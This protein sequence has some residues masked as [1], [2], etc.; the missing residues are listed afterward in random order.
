MSEAR[1]I[2]AE[3]AQWLSRRADPDW[4]AG[5]QAELDRWLAQGHAHK[6]AFWR[7]QEGWD[8]AGRLSALGLP[9]QMK[10]RWTARRGSAW[11]SAALAASAAVGIWVGAIQ[12]GL[13]PGGRVSQEQGQ[14]IT[15]A[16]GQHRIVPLDDGSAIELNTA[17]IVRAAV[18]PSSREV[19]LDKGEAFFDVLHSNTVPFVVHAGPNTVTVLGTKFSV[20]RDGNDVT[21]AVL[22]GRVRLSD[23]RAPKDSTSTAVAAGSV[24]ITK[25]DATLVTEGAPQTVQAELAWR[26]GQL[27]FRNDTLAEAAAEFNRYNER[28]LIV[29]GES[30]NL[31]ISGSFKSRNVDG[32]ARLLRDAYGLNVAIDPKEV[33]VSG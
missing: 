16:V 22:S 26:K 29:S 15:T 11:K 13:M 23:A 6:A 20:K 27:M 28:K 7:L 31:K 33:R 10:D 24:A 18:T 2:E 32:F 9:R 19:W 1:R 30:A 12:F 14:V 21:I 8:R 5:E 3:A 17:T 25:P 4:T